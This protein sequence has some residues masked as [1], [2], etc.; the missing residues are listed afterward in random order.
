MTHSSVALLV[1]GD[2]IPPSFA[3]QILRKASEVGPQSARFAFCNTQSLAGWSAA[4]SFR[5]IHSGTGKNGSDIL[6]S[7]RA[8]ELALRDGIENFVIVSSDSDLSHVAHRLRELGRHVLGLGEDKAPRT[9]RL[10]C[11]RFQILTPPPAKV[12][13]SNLGRID[14]IVRKVLEEH[15]PDGKGLL[16]NRSNGLVRNAAT[17]PVKISQEPEKNWPKYLANRQNLYT[18]SY[19][20]PSRTVRIATEDELT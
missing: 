11:T 9:L 6:L 2:N 13:D 18:V 5:A 19:E 17:P 1:D 12:E 20:G 15:D 14:R 4:P 8:I 3:G 16:L 7:I 10:A